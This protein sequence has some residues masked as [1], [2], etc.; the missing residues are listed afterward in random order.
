MSCPLRGGSG[1]GGGGGGGDGRGGSGGTGQWQRRQQ[2][3][4]DCWQQHCS[5]RNW[6]ERKRRRSEQQGLNRQRRRSLLA[7]RRGLLAEAAATITILLWAASYANAAPCHPLPTQQ[8]FLWD[9]QFSGPHLP[10]WA[11]LSEY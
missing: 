9:V 1:G 10:T 6:R 4:Q 7:S 2:R 3:T 8:N 11:F 5:E